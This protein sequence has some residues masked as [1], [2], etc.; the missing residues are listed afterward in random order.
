MIVK[1]WRRRRLNGN[2]REARENVV[3]RSEGREGIA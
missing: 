1:G 3:V 2:I